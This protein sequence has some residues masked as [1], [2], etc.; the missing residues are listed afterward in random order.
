MTESLAKASLVTQIP[1][2]HAPH[3]EEAL[4]KAR[5]SQANHGRKLC[6][7]VFRNTLHAE[8][9]VDSSN[10]LSI[11]A[12]VDSLRFGFVSYGSPSRRAVMSPI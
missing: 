1:L 12:K 9:D 10:A 11:I 8:F 5:L 3:T 4:D 7:A 6:D 2:P